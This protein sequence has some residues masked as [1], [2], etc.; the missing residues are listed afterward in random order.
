M[1][2]FTMIINYII[3]IL[4]GLLIGYL[5]GFSS[6]KKEGVELTKT[7]LPLQILKKSMDQGYCLICR[8]KIPAS[9][10]NSEGNIEINNNRDKSRRE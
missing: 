8:E 10:R 9:G 2:V 7:K 5:A 4:I 6:G 1:V 3:C